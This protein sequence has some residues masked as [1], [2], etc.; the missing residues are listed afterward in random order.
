[1]VTSEEQELSS[2]PRKVSIYSYYDA[3]NDVTFLSNDEFSLEGEETEIQNITYQK[4]DFQEEE[5]YEM[6]LID[7]DHKLLQFK[8]G[9]KQL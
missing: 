3:E 8:S 9:L 1:M 4:T 2:S 6:I 5:E 7:E